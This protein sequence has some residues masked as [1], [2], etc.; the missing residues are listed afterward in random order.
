MSK[1]KAKGTK[2]FQGQFQE[3]AG[4]CIV[5]TGYS[6]TKQQTEDYRTDCS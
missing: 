1:A 6:R 5:T 4:I 2:L 3:Q